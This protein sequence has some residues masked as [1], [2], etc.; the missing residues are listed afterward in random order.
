MTNARGEINNLSE[1]LS[2]YV[3]KDSSV[4]LVRLI[5][6][7]IILVVGVVIG[8]TS[9]PLINRYFNLQADQFYRNYA[10]EYDLVP[11]VSGENCTIVEKCEKEDCQNMASFLGP[12]NLTHG[13]SDEELFWRASMV[14]RKADFPYARIPKV[15]F[16]FLTRGQLPMLP[17]WERFF[18]DHEKLF[19][20]YVHAIP[21]Y[22]LNVSSTSPFY[23]RQIP[24]QGV[25][26]G[27]VSLVDAERRLLANA[28][29]D[30]SNE[31]FVLLSESCI[32]IYNFST[33]YKYL[34]GSNHSFVETYDDP[35]R[36][37]RG[38]YNRR[39]QPDIKLSDWRKGS[40]WFEVHRILATIIVSD[41]K[42][43]S[44]LRKHCKPACYPDE[45]YLPTFLH[46]FYGSLNA[47]RSLTWVDWSMGG[48]HPATF[49]E[50]NITEGFIQSIR[51]NGTTC[52]YNS[53]KTSVCYL[54][55]RKFGPGALEPLL[56][57]TST[58]MKI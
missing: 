49:R 14:P 37:G 41:S 30:F 56:N 19:S 27:S 2:G 51:N 1:K 55:A 18:Q 12:K 23:R 44:L 29:L 39:M 38:R 58:L 5:S 45:H 13:M 48:P 40:Q 42:Y 26:W 31:R 57:L 25:S 6:V 4:G 28:L 11:A 46:M 54:F 3:L 34:I 15:A 10:S 32:P 33:I 36:S 20:I 17:L 24:S 21:G 8:L 43:Y 7:L 22:E 47:N 16:M 52:S 9:S 35:S 53:G 50:T